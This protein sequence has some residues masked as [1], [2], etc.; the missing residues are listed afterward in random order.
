MLEEIP[1]QMGNSCTILGKEFYMKP[2]QMRLFG[3]CEMLII[4]NLFHFRFYEET[5]RVTKSSL[6]PTGY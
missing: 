6:N 4:Q 3:L 2:Q 5:N 1:R